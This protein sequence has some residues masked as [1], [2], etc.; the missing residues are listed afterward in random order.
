MN[1]SRLQPE[2][3]AH[4]DTNPSTL[5]P[6]HCQDLVFFHCCEALCVSVDQVLVRQKKGS[7]SHGSCCSMLPHANSACSQPAHSLLTTR[8]PQRFAYGAT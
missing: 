4:Q 2:R 3:A 7:R 5:H 8:R 6:A 1:I